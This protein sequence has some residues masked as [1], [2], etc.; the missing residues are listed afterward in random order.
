MLRSVTSHA[1]FSPA[2]Q[3]CQLS[4]V[5]LQLFCSFCASYIILFPVLSRSFY[6]LFAVCF[7]CSSASWSF[8]MLSCS[9]PPRFHHL[10]A[11]SFPTTAN[12]TDWLIDY[13]YMSLID[14]FFI[15]WWTNER[16]HSWSRLVCDRISEFFLVNLHSIPL[17]VYFPQ[18]NYETFFVL[19]TWLR[20]IIDLLLRWKLDSR[21]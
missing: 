4:D 14:Y 2:A 16:A 19:T 11:H 18:R 6:S 3:Q 17:A 20:I 9:P 10:S 5:R 15:Y 12:T 21:L 1:L 13:A 7:C 8:P